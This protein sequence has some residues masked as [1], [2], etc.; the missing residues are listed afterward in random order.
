MA[1]EPDRKRVEAQTL[2]QSSGLTLAAD[3]MERVIM[4]YEHFSAARATLSS[5]AMGEV[6][7]ATIFQAC[8]QDDRP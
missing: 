3:E 5:Q 7:P 4:L 1:D 2:I 8:R 6:E